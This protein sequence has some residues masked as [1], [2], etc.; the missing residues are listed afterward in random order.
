MAFI[1]RKKSELHLRR[2]G[3]RTTERFPTIWFPPDLKGLYN[4][5]EAVKR[6]KELEQLHQNEMGGS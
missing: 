2:L 4:L 3:W 1:T 6:Q 5:T